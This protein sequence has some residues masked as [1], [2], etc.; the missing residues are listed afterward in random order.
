MAGGNRNRKRGSR[1]RGFLGAARIARS[2][3]KRRSISGQWRH[4]IAIRSPSTID[5]SV[6]RNQRNAR[7]SVFVRIRVYVCQLIAPVIRAR[8]GEGGK[9]KFHEIAVQ[10]FVLDKIYRMTRKR[11]SMQY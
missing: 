5:L 3:V 8:A 1:R 6:Y 4:T 10:R 7:V 9:W 2:R 11:T